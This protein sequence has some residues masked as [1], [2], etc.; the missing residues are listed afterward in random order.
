ME[1]FQLSL[2]TDSMSLTLDQLDRHFAEKMGVSCEQIQI[3][4]QKTRCGS[5]SPKTGTLSLIFRL[6]MVPPA[7]VDY[8]LTHELA[9]AEHP[10]HGPRFWRLVEQYVPDYEA[11]N[12]WLKENGTALTFG[13]QS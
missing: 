9:H 5:Y 11:K 8:V 2:G 3:R 12:E 7:V 10:N 13:L 4:N 1:R 6:L